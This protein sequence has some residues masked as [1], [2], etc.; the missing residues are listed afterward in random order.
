MES[1]LLSLES[2][3]VEPVSCL[4]LPCYQY[5][6]IVNNT[7]GILH[8]HL[9]LLFQFHLFL[10]EFF[11]LHTHILQLQIGIVGFLCCYFMLSWNSGVQLL[12]IIRID[13]GRRCVAKDIFVPEFAYLI[14]QGIKKNGVE[15]RE[16][17]PEVQP[18]LEPCDAPLIESTNPN[19]VLVLS[20][21]SE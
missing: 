12:D 1:G 14:D 7:L 8:Y 4:L 16:R 6:V 18:P 13:G 17:L 20:L 3:L 10:F 21:P 9:H 11:Y 2:G 19:L 5:F 15:L